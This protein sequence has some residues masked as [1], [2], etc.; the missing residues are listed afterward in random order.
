M[1]IFS[2][3]VHFTDERSCRLHFKEHRDQQGVIC[4]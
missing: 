1:D 4:H 3:G 2:F